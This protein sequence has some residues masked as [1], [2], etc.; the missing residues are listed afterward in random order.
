MGSIRIEFSE[1]YD[2]DPKVE[3]FTDARISPAPMAGFYSLSLFSGE[4]VRIPIM[5]IK[6]VQEVK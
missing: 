2:D 4:T 6:R 3:V 1:E 5:R